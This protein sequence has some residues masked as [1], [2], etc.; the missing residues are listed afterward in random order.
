MICRYCKILLVNITRRKIKSPA[1]FLQCMKPWPTHFLSLPLGFARGR[2][3][4]RVFSLQTFVASASGHPEQSHQWANSPSGFGS[5]EGHSFCPAMTTPPSPLLLGVP[6]GKEPVIRGGKRGGRRMRGLVGY[7]GSGP[8]VSTG[9]GGVM[10]FVSNAL[11]RGRQRSCE[12][13]ESRGRVVV[14]FTAGGRKA[15][16]DMCRL[17]DGLHF[18]RSAC[19]C[20]YDLLHVVYIFLTCF[21]FF[22][23]HIKGFSNLNSC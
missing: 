20:S 3:G 13:M 5:A 9:G 1:F 15:A 18:V 12:W 7:T 11:C 19:K 8:D 14:N 22:M 21:Y 10:L 17:K 4:S 16:K 2:P 23:V 6:P